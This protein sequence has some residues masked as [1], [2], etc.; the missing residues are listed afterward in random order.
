MSGHVT[1]EPEW[2][3]GYYQVAGDGKLVCNG[4]IRIQ[5]PD[6]DAA[7]ARWHE[8]FAGPPDVALFSIEGPPPP[9]M[10]GITTA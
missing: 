8:I 3:L 7:I 10:P 2:T 4:A 1:V 6:R 9:P 5:A